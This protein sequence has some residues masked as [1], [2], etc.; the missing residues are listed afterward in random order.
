M[1][2]TKN[3]SIQ[4]FL[5]DGHGPQETT[6]FRF[7]APKILNLIRESGQPELHMGDFFKL[8]SQ[9]IK[10][11]RYDIEPVLDCLIESGILL[12]RPKSKYITIRRVKNENN[13]P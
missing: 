12:R 13:N 8:C 1:A 11:S 2:L 6:V 10:I 9:Q 5:T 7:L 4:E 3:T